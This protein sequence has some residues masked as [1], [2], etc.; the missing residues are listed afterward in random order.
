MNKKV[1]SQRGVALIDAL[2]AMV[3]LAFGLLG[4][5]SLQVRVTREATDGQTRVLASRMADELLSL[6]LVDRT[7]AACYVLPTAAAGCTS[8]VARTAATTWSTQAL[9]ALPPGATATSELTDGNQRLTVTI[10]WTDRAAA[11]PRTLGMSTG[12]AL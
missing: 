7:S 10:T 8:T 3:I 11:E 5:A 12:V 1:C 2:I 9:A 4:V 6:A